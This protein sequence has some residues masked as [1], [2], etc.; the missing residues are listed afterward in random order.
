MVHMRLCV[1]RVSVVKCFSEFDHHGDTEGHRDL[2]VVRKI[3]LTQSFMQSRGGVNGEIEEF[4]IKSARPSQS[5]SG[6]T[7]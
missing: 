4:I 3:V 6:R 5:L 2:R 1:L 7:L